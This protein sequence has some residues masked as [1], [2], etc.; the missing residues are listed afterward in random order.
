MKIRLLLLAL[1]F[2]AAPATLPVGLAN[3]ARLHGASHAALASDDPAQ[4]FVDVSAY[5]TDDAHINAWYALVFGLKQNFDDICGDT[6]CEGEYSNI[7]SMRYRCSVE[8][9]AGTIGSCVWVF[10]A[11]NEEINPRTGKVV[12]DAQ[13]WR[14]RSPLASGT[15]ILDFLSALAGTSPMYATLPA[16]TR[17]IYDGLTNCL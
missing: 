1:L 7:E 15:H 5:L 13:A 11:S 3:G 12:V 4:E 2:S 16:T 8:K 10:A 9:N 17:S 14:C 6:F